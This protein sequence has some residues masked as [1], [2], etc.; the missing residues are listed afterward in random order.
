MKR[1][2]II[3]PILSQEAGF[4]MCFRMIDRKSDRQIIYRLN[5]KIR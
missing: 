5:R 4:V 3:H 1:L 2:F